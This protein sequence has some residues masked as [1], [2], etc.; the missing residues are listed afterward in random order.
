MAGIIFLFL[1]LILVSGFFSGSESALFSLKESQLTRFKESQRL[2]FRRVAGMMR[3]PEKVLIAILL[4]NLGV[5]MAISLTGHR[6]V[7]ELFEGWGNT[8]IISLFLITII[9]VIMAE[10]IPKVLALRHAE[11][12]S[13]RSAPFLKFWIW[14][15]KP[16]ALP[17]LVLTKRWSEKVDSGKKVIEEK[18]L[19]D[20]VESAQSRGILGEDEEGMLKR[21]IRFYHDTAYNVMIPK[22]ECLMIPDNLDYQATARIFHEKRNPAAIVYEHKTGKVIGYVHVRSLIPLMQGKRRTIKP[23][24]QEI[25]YL[26]KTLSLNVVLEEFLKQRIEVAAVI[27]EMGEFSGVIRMKEIFQ[28]LMGDLSEEYLHKTAPETEHITK[29]KKDTYVVEGSMTMNDFNEYFGSNL[30]STGSETISGF[31][32]EKLDGYP[33][34]DTIFEMENMKFYHMEM[35]KNKISQVRVIVRNA[36]RK[37]N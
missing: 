14:V 15:S 17:A 26:P 11:G 3:S 22:S 13:V 20:A 19:I 2:M 30:V 16:F 21:A 34:F 23:A 27:D 24:I 35:H 33:R 10:T 8:E 37:E 1:F 28:S 29:V 32:I 6:I 18:E 31:L 36:N 12:W 5:N 25:L 4:G 9:L 7:A